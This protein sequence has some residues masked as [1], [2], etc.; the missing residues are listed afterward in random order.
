MAGWRY[1][2]EASG[3]V[4]D[5]QL[6]TGGQ[7][8]LDALAERG[9]VEVGLVG[10]YGCEWAKDEARVGEAV[11]MGA[12]CVGV[13]D[14]AAATFEVWRETASAAGAASRAKVW[15]VAG[16]VRG[17]RVE[18]EAPFAFR[19]GREGALASDSAAGDGTEAPMAPPPLPGT[20]SG[21]ED[22]SDGGL[23]ASS[24]FVAD[25]SV[26]GTYRARSAPL[27]LVDR[28]EVH[29]VDT[30]GQSVEAAEYHVRLADGSVRTGTTDRNGRLVE[31]DVP[32]GSQLLGVARPS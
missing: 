7:V 31:D 10:V 11:G 5:G 19:H 12:R 28:V 29:V 15:E 8:W 3:G 23:G 32:L 9:A 27:R 13:A 17:G 21:T 24:L 1:H 20:P 2:A 4:R 16:A 26:G 14:G 6:G 30:D 18:A 25:V 22:G